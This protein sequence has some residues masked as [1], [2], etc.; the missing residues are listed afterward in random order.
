MPDKS[1]SYEDNIT[2][3]FYVDNTCIDCDACR[4][5]AP[6]NFNRNEDGG[7]SYV[8]KQPESEDEYQMCLDAIEG[9]PVDAIGEDGDE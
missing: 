7:Y 4:V 5:A 1:A 3:V 9:C 6:D 2:G 8:D